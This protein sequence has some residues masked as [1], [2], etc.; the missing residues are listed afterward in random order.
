MYDHAHP[1]LLG[2]RDVV[3]A[4]LVCIAVAG[5]IFVYPGFVADPERKAQAALGNTAPDDSRA[6]LCAIR[7]RQVGEKHG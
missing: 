7:N 6:A 5:A 2:A 1:A 4:W 3:A